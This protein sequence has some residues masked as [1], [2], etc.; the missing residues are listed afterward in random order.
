MTGGARA[1]R[2]RTRLDPGVRREQII[3]AAEEVFAGRDP[4]EVTLEEIAEQAGVSRALVYN[5]FGDKSGVIAAVY[6]RCSQRL[7]EALEP[8][9]LALDTTLCDRLHQLVEVYLR[10]ATEHAAAWKLVSTAEATVHPLVLQARRWRDEQLA[11]AWGGTAEAR[12]LA[13]GVL[14]CLEAATLDWLDSREPPLDRAVAV[15]HALLW[16]GLRGLRTHPG[17]LEVVSGADT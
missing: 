2:T 3:D 1:G 6:L 8:V 4:N 10:F 5:Y 16:E 11:T 7:D 12:L 15:I 14:G 9:H 13:R 17:S